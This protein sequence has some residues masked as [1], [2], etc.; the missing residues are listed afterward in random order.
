LHCPPNLESAA[1]PY[2]STIFHPCLVLGPDD[3]ATLTLFR[4]AQSGIGMRVAGEP[5]R[6][7]FVDVRDVVS[8][9][10][11]MAEDT[12][13][14]VFTYFV[15]HPD[16][17]DVRSL[18]RHLEEAL[19]RKVRVIPLHKAI[20]YGAMRVATLASGLIGF[21]NQLDVKQYTQMVSPAFL[22]SS[23]ALRR[24]LGWIPLHEAGDACRNAARGY[25][26]S[27]LLRN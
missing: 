7:S 8:T 26:A 4:A 11:C 1:A 15:A 20:L 3:P 16:P 27:R 12:R 25:R 5:Q 24:D 21:D 6:L 14:G 13:T 2:S 10:I 17:I 22:C 19:G 9:I 23:A 18:W